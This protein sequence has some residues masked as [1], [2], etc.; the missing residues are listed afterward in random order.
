ME[1]IN[2]LFSFYE[3]LELFGF[4]ILSLIAGAAVKV[5]IN[6]IKGWNILSSLFVFALSGFVMVLAFLCANPLLKEPGAITKVI[7]ILI[8][9]INFIVGWLKYS[10]GDDE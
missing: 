7:A 10:C 9:T 4:V 6:E 3:W 5:A 1:K 2:L 8:F